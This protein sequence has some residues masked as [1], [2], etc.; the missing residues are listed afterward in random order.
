MNDVSSLNR[1]KEGILASLRARGPS[2]PVQVAKA[3]NTSPL[4]ASAFLS[5]LKGEDKIKISN[6]RVGS[7][8][9]YYLPGDEEKLENYSQ[10]LNQRER[11]AFTLL[12]N[13]KVL[14]DEEQ[15][16]VVRVALR[17][18]KDFAIPLNVKIDETQK[19]FWKYFTLNDGEASEKIKELINGPSEKKKIDEKPKEKVEEENLETKEEVLKEEVKEEVVKEN[20]KEEIKE[21]K[22]IEEVVWDF[23]SELKN[24]LEILNLE[25]MEVFSEKKKEFEARVRTDG[26]FG[27]QEYYLVAKDK[28]N[29]NDK[30][31][32]KAWQKAHIKKM[33][34]IF[35]SPGEINK[36][37][38][39]HLRVWGNLVKF[40]K[41][42]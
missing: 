36:K 13:S 17:A 38:K 10:Y 24:H 39:E 32:E 20:I 27:K 33:S 11:E 14:Q 6:M 8:P 30:D 25:V 40:E 34:A 42:N 28:K 26:K 29:I 7:S 5:E 23:A 3:I 12:R 19:I 18:I 4:F 16:P 2:L 37:G 9:I 35:I 1:N 41:L 21:E 31:F 15:T 22:K